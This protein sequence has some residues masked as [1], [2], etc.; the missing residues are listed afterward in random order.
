M[1]EQDIINFGVIRGVDKHGDKMDGVG[2]LR[3]ETDKHYMIEF[4]G[5][6]TVRRFKKESYTFERI[7]FKPQ[8]S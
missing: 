1:S 7:E 5:D 8:A 6:D 3:G 4:A 2:V